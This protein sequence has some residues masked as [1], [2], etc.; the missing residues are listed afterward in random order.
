M[1][2]QA[3]VE[4]A[5]YSLH[6][7]VTFTPTKEMKMKKIL[8]LQKLQTEETTEAAGS[9]SSVFCIGQEKTGGDSGCSVGCGG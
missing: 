7:A 5:S 3:V 9:T 8:D 6:P 1:D 4:L 2:S